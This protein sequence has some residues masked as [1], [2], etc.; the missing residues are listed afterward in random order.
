MKNFKACQKRARLL[1]SKHQ[2]AK[3]E[4]QI[5]LETHQEFRVVILEDVRC[6]TCCRLLV[7]IASSEDTHSSVI[8][9]RVNT[10]SVEAQSQY[11]DQ[12]T[13]YLYHLV[14]GLKV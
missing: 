10:T 13:V 4:Q 9:S 6:F 11:Y 12:H 8:C 2:E 1:F 3:T 7:G 5:R 14:D